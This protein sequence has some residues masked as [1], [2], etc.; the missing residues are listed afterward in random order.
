VDKFKKTIEKDAALERRFQ[1]VFVDQPSVPTTVSILRGLRSRYENYHGE[2]LTCCR[3]SAESKRVLISTDTLWAQIGKSRLLGLQ[4]LID[5]S[6]VCVAASLSPDRF[7]TS[8][9][10]AEQ[11]LTAHAHA[12]A[13]A[14][15]VPGPVFGSGFTV[16]VQAQCCGCKCS[17]S[18][19]LVLH[20]CMC[21]PGRC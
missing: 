4:V 8:C 10:N 9:A 11:P 20:A 6:M 19:S 1:Q 2:L 13:H 5:Q 16:S 18:L 17:I 12:H 7:F 21:A 14:G 3:Y 15:S